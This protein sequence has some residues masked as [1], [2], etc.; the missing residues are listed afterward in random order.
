MRKNECKSLRVALCHC[1]NITVD[2]EDAR[3]PETVTV[4]IV[5]HHAKLV[6][7][8]YTFIRVKYI[9]LYSFKMQH[10]VWVGE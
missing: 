8:V 3:G 7:R 9:Q 1:L 5:T 2:D 4:L 10:F 6:N